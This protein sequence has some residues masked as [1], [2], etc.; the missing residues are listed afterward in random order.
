[1]AAENLPTTPSPTTRA[2]PIAIDD[3]KQD[4][5]DEEPVYISGTVGGTQSRARTRV[6]FAH[7]SSSKYST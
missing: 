5:S 6:T 3:T 7:S 1:M 2:P 4:D